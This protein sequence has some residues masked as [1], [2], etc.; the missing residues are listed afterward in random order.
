VGV[1]ALAQALSSMTGLT[2][3]DLGGNQLG[4]AGVAPSP[5]SRRRSPS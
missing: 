5:P 2:L 3:L 4:D 1:A